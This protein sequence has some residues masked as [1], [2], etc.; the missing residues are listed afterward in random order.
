M[1]PRTL[2][3]TPLLLAACHSG[4]LSPTEPRAHDTGADPELL[5]IVSAWTGSCGITTVTQ[6][7][8][9]QA[10]DGIEIDVALA[11]SGQEVVC[12]DG[13]GGE[14][15]CYA[16]SVPAA[17]ADWPGSGSGQLDLL[18][19]GPIDLLLEID[20]QGFCDPDAP[21]CDPSWE[22]YLWG[23]V[24]DG[25]F[26]GDCQSISSGSGEQQPVTWGTGTFS[27]IRG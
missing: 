6:P 19:G 9:P 14:H 27:F 20:A 4:Y 23:D 2:A 1:H 5:E 18:G 25:V 17:N 26:T 21:G 16:V 3:L 8:T 12:E 11:I 7:A 24:I 22:L 15:A 13:F 10:Q